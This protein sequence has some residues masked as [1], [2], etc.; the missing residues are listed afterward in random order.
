MSVLI[1]IDLV[2]SRTPL[3]A[4]PGQVVRRGTD[5]VTG[6]VWYYSMPKRLVGGGAPFTERKRCDR[7]ERD[8]VLIGGYGSGFWACPGCEDIEDERCKMM[9]S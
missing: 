5:P 1:G 9:S 6:E 3:P 4:T 7:C 8:K 2:E